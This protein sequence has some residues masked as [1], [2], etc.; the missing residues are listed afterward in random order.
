MAGVFTIALAGYGLAHGSTESNNAFFLSVAGIFVAATVPALA[1][2]SNS[3]AIWVRA[4][5]L[6]ALAVMAVGLYWFG[7]LMFHMVIEPNMWSSRYAAVTKPLQIESVSEALY[8]LVPCDANT[9]AGIILTV[10]LKLPEIVSVDRFGR[11]VLKSMNGFSILR[12]T[13]KNSSR[14]SLFKN[15]RNPVVT[16]YN[17]KPLTDLPSMAAY[18]KL[19]YNAV[20]GGSLQLPAGVYMVKQIFWRSG[21]RQAMSELPTA[22]PL[23]AIPYRKAYPADDKYLPYLEN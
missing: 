16:T 4:L 9:Q 14:T 10:N 22:D 5:Q 23:N 2:L 18:K 1:V 17:S 8:L 11:S 6:I 13:A 21:L 20:L 15:S 19:A 12:A 3:R 7:T